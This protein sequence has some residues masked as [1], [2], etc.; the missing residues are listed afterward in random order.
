[1]A[2]PWDAQCS[3]FSLHTVTT[4]LLPDQRPRLQQLGI[5]LHDQLR[6][7]ET[8]LDGCIFAPGRYEKIWPANVLPKD[9]L[10][11]GKCT[12]QPVRRAPPCF[13]CS[14]NRSKVR[15]FRFKERL[16]REGRKLP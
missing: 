8:N 10:M 14:G 1:A 16:R 4:S 5:V 3:Q 2:R 11:L 13:Q 6:A 9:S 7:L 12:L 15:A